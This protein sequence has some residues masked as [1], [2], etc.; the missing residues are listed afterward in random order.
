MELAMVSAQRAFDQGEFPVGAVIV[1][2]G[3]VVAEGHRAGSVGFTGRPCEIDHAEIRALRQLTSLGSDFDPG[4]A[5]IF[6]TMEPCL[7]CFA[8]IILSGIKEVVYAYEDIMGGG[9]GCDLQSLPLLYKKCA[10]RVVPG[11]LR[12]KSLDLFVKFF[13]KENNLYWKDSLLEHYTLTQAGI[14]LK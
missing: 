6:S 4:R 12:E 8:A 1:S 11:V 13:Q 14:I 5:V 3:R 9:T 10:V 7:M 2:D